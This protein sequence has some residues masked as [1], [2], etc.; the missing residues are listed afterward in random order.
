MHC[1]KRNICSLKH[2]CTGSADQHSIPLSPITVFKQQK[3]PQ[4]VEIQSSSKTHIQINKA[5]RINE[6]STA[7]SPPPFLHLLFLGVCLLQTMAVLHWELYIGM[8]DEGICLTQGPV[9]SVPM[10]IS[11]HHSSASMVIHTNDNKRQLEVSWSQHNYKTQ[12]KKGQSV[13]RNRSNGNTEA[14]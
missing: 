1:T 6:L 3:K 7:L 4:V 14:G 13:I 5:Q 8:I 11:A 12:E 9:F 10:P 2:R